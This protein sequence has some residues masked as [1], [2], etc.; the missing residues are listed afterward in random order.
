VCDGD[1]GRTEEVLR[2]HLVSTMRTLGLAVQHP[3]Q[4]GDGGG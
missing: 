4:S 1:L 3:A 2:T